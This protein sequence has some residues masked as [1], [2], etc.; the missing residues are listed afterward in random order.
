MTLAEVVWL[1]EWLTWGFNQRER[2]SEHRYVEMIKKWLSLGFS[3][4]ANECTN[5]V[6]LSIF[7]QQQ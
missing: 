5:S 7:S 6:F 2:K 4:I 1:N 3:E